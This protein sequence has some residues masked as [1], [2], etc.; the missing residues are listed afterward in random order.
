[1][2]SGRC[3][4]AA[5]DREGADKLDATASGADHFCHVGYICGCPPAAWYSRPLKLSHS[6]VCIPFHMWS[7]KDLLAHLDHHHLAS[8]QFLWKT[9]PLSHSTHIFLD[10]QPA[11]S[12]AEFQ[13][14]FHLPLGAYIFLKYLNF[15]CIVLAF[16][17]AIDCSRRTD[18]PL[19]MNPYRQ[20]HH[21]SAR[22][23]CPCNLF[24]EKVSMLRW[25]L[26]FCSPPVIL[27][28]T[29][30]YFLAFPIAWGRD[31][32]TWG[33]LQT[34]SATLLSFNKSQYELLQ[35]ALVTSAW[36]LTAH[37]GVRCLCGS[38]SS[39]SWVSSPVFKGI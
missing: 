28:T 16:A 5:E 32:F 39:A 15:A 35:Q 8:T 14:I 17:P 24:I 9:I 22:F 23:S 11:I 2:S 20:A 33:Q 29:V 36:L 26:A 3:C 1:M 4:E 30:S 25:E 38:V 19:W 10:I 18:W 13:S 7:G 37:W 12:L 27:A 21:R 34:G 31:I 6:N